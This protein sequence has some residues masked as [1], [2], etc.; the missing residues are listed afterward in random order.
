MFLM[1]WELLLTMYKQLFGICST[2]TNEDIKAQA[3]L[4][5][6]QFDYGCLIGH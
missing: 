1:K 5:I 3:E 4:L 6:S 2:T